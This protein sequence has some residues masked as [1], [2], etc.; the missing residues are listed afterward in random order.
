MDPTRGQISWSEL[1]VT[2][3]HTGDIS[4]AELQTPLVPTSGAISWGELQVTI[5]TAGLIGWGELQTPFVP[6][7]G[8]IGWGELQTPL[9]PTAGQISQAFVDIAKA[10]TRGRIGYAEFVLPP[11]LSSGQLS[12]VW[13]GLPKSYVS[14]FALSNGT[15]DIFRTAN[16][17]AIQAAGQITQVGV[18][19]AGVYYTEA[20]DIIVTAQHS[21][22]AGI[23]EDAV[24]SVVIGAQA[25]KAGTYRTTKGFLSSDKFI[26]DDTYYN[27]HTYVVR[28]A[29][30]FDR[31]KTIYKKILHPAGF[32]LVGEFVAV[33][34]PNEFTETAVDPIITVI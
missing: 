26:Q 23:S 33:M 3:G 12:T 7:A 11:V 6:T 10:L 34:V 22:N 25:T 28:V 1:D 24:L 4:W 15:V 13:L 30:S 16:L 17:S 8:L 20:N 29:E 18:T 2:W 21:S 14:S 32:N 27:D 31:W 5:A 19:S 9:V